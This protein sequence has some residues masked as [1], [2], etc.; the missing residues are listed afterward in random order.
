MDYDKAQF[1]SQFAGTS[2]ESYQIG[3]I[4]L[5]SSLPDAWEAYLEIPVPT[6][7]PIMYHSDFCMYENDTIL[8]DP[9][10]QLG[11]SQP[12]VIVLDEAYSPTPKIYFY[13]S[14][15]SDDTLRFGVAAS[16]L[17]YTRSLANT[18]YAQW[19]IWVFATHWVT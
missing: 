17:G 10:V 7:V 13:I 19:R 1:G 4:N 8:M 3:Y 15:I 6:D 11:N 16:T 12:K 18:Y 5:P 2:F 9:G 14:R